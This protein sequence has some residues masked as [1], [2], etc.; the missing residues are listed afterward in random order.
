MLS[1]ITS[2]KKIV[3]V[4]DTLVQR[5]FEENQETS[6][7]GIE[8]IDRLI[9]RYEELISNLRQS[10]SSMSK[11]IQ[12]LSEQIK[13]QMEVQRKLAELATVDELTGTLNRRAALEI[14]EKLLK[15]NLS[16]VSLCYFDVDRL[17]FVNDNFGH[18]V[19]DILLRHVINKIKKYLRRSDHI[20]RMGGDEF[21]II[22]PEVRKKR[23]RAYNAKNF[24]CT[25]R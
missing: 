17:K 10:A 22:L 2:A 13:F 1:S 8:E 11:Q 9:R 6:Q 21:L 14:L 18:D 25:Q 12:K 15:T 4:I 24:K 7:T 5:V 20:A 23:S 3:N 16:V 19:G